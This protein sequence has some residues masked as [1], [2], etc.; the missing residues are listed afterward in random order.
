MIFPESGPARE[1]VE[2]CLEELLAFTG[3][4]DPHDDQV[5]AIAWAARE[6]QEMECQVGVGMEALFVLGGKYATA[7]PLGYMGRPG[8]SG[9]PPWWINGL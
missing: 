3:D 7:G 6:A 4:D 8:G 2:D 9:R 1:W 5:D